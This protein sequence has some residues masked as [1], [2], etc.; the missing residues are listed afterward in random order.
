MKTQIN[1][2]EILKDCPKG[3]KLYSPAFGELYLTHG[4]YK[5]DIHTIDM[6]GDIWNFY[7]D[8]RY[9]DA[10]DECMLFPSKDQRDWS[11]FEKPFMLPFEIKKHE[12]K[13]YWCFNSR[14]DVENEKDMG[15]VTDNKRFDMGNYFDTSQQADY[16]AQ[17]VKELLLSLR[18]E[19]GNE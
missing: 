1:I 10:S 9:S 5:K 2:A 17:K 3:T 6:F 7:T 18:K 19:E 16:A 11:K 12:G 14:G 8:G 15:Y 4:D 13:R